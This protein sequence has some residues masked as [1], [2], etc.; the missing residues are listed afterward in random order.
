M[1]CCNQPNVQPFVLNYV[2][3]IYPNGFKEPPEYDYSAT[4]LKANELHVKKFICL[5][6]HRVILAPNVYEIRRSNGS[7][8]NNETQ[9]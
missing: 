8:P 9:T 7:N 4:A 6:C 3:K 1:P 5:N 2:R